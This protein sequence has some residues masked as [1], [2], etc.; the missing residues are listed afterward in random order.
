MENQ[1]GLVKEWR[2]E[3]EASNSAREFVNLE[4]ECLRDA[5]QRFHRNLVLRAF[6]VSDVI[7]GKISLFR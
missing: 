4:L 1:I 7:P 2:S 6:D 5:R 3:T